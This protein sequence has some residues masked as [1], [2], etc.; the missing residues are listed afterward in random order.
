MFQEI[1]LEDLQPA[2]EKIR[3]LTFFCQHS[4]SMNS[5]RI[6]W[7]SIYS[8]VFFEK[9]KHQKKCYA[10]HLG[11]LFPT[12]TTTTEFH[13]SFF[14]TLEF[15][16]PKKK[17]Y[18]QKWHQMLPDLLHDAGNVGSRIHELGRS[19]MSVKHHGFHTL[20]DERDSANRCSQ[21]IFSHFWWWKMVDES[22]LQSQSVKK[23][24]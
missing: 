2:G 11:C 12:T 22:F 21:Q 1:Y 16:P 4:L 14:R 6:S 3:P 9:K 5:T 19:S 8:V 18:K 15:H 20:G 13:L 10:P 7:T 17:N 23:S 24:P